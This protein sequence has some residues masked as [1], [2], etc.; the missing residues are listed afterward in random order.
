MPSDASYIVVTAPTT[1]NQ[2]KVFTPQG[3]RGQD[4]ISALA[5]QLDNFIGSTNTVAYQTLYNQYETLVGQ[6]DTCN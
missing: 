6:Y 4:Q 1:G 2:Y 5:V 3:K